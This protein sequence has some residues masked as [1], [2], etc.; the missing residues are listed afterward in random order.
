MH[1]AP[2]DLPS[3]D[4][5]TDLPT[6]CA[7]GSSEQEKLPGDLPSMN[8]PTDLPMIILVEPVLK[9]FVVFRAS[10]FTLLS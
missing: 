3:T 4:L 6:Q 1:N 10:F 2:G 8:P 9:V 5:S 7:L